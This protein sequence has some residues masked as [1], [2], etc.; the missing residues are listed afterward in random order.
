MIRILFIIA[1]L[2]KLEIN[3]KKIKLNPI[4]AGVLE[5][6]DLMG[7]GGQV[8]PPSKSHVRCLKMTNDTSLENSTFR[9]CKKKL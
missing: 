3:P 7:G 5:N 8:D 6:Q 9:I 1:L 4:P 2:R